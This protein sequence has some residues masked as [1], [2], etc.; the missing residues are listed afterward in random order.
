[1]TG[2]TSKLNVRID[3]GNWRIFLFE[4]LSV[5]GIIF[6]SIKAPFPAHSSS[7]W[8]LI[9]FNYLT[10]KTR[11]SPGIP[12]RGSLPSETQFPQSGLLH[13]RHAQRLVPRDQGDHRKVTKALF[14]CFC[15]DSSPLVAV[16]AS[17][18]TSYD[19]PAF[20]LVLF[21]CFINLSSSWDLT[22]S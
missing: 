14:T 13:Q 15:F 12:Q 3:F 10:I 11:M 7:Y 6:P 22:M 8:V 9:M 5:P 4:T 18:S 20:G 2:S 19:T 21:S 17:S 16:C 1:M